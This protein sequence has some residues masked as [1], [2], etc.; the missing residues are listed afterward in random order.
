MNQQE[1]YLKKLH[2]HLLIIMDEID[3]VCTIN[4]IRYYLAAGSLIGAVRHR[5]FIPWDD[6]MD[7]NMPYDDFKR[8]VEIAPQVL[9]EKFYFRW[10]TTEKN[11]PHDFA[12][13]SMKGTLFQEHYTTDMNHSGIFVDIFPMYPTSCYRRMYDIKKRLTTFLHGCLYERGVKSKKRRLRDIPRLLISHLFSSKAIFKLTLFVIHPKR[14]ESAT[15][16]A[17]YPSLY[18]IK[19]QICP[20]EWC[21]EGVRLPF[22]DRY[23]ICPLESL[24]KIKLEYGENVLQL[25]PL[26]KRKMHYPLKVIFSDGQIMEFSPCEQ[27]VSYNDILN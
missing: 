8:F 19:R 10:I 20:K 23:Y 11:Y 3:R 15:H 24:K 13:V 5:G 25:P 14:D 1:V 21:G 22:E 7:I 12:K 18:P 16:Y 9:G 4:G 26:E 17:C 2:E 6:D 27:V